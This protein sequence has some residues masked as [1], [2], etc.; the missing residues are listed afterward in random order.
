MFYM[1]VF[2]PS[3]NVLILGIFGNRAQGN[4]GTLRTDKMVS[5]DYR[6]TFW[7]SITR[8]QRLNVLSGMVENYIIFQKNSIP[9]HVMTI[10]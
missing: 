5:G 3:K 7:I 8:A 10:C 2:T 9:G 6:S 1:L 4:F